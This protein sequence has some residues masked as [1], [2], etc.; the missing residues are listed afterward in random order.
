[1]QL[2]GRDGTSFLLPGFIVSFFVTE[3][4]FVF[5]N[6]LDVRIDYIN[7]SGGEKEK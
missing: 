4:E 3:V 5:R 1:M 6:D 7:S 2:L